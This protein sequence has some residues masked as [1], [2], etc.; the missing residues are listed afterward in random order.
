MNIVIKWWPILFRGGLYFLMESLP[1]LYIGFEKIG[2]DELK[3]NSWLLAALCV[4]ALYHGCIGLRAYTDTS[5]HRLTDSIRQH[6]GD[7]NR[8]TKP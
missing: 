6:S 8:F 7:T 1:V 2:K 3:V 4:N 5:F